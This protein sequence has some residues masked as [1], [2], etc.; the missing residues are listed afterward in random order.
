VADALQQVYPEYSWQ[1]ERFVDD[2]RATPG[3]WKAN[4][5]HIASALDR[6]E[7]R[8][9]ITQVLLCSFPPSPPHTTT[10]NEVNYK[11]AED[12]YTVSLADLRR[13]GFPTHQ[14]TKAQLAELLAT[15][16]PKFNWENIYLQRGRYA[17]Q[18]RLQKTV[19]S[20]FPV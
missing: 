1:L 2:G 10:L 6:A 14:L 16:Y 12:W 18:K 19:T 8:L 4:T 5:S 13:V 11:Q 20:L 9:G 7:R 3:Y 15:K 17:E